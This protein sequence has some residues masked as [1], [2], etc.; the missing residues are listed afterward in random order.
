MSIKLDLSQK[1]SQSLRLSPQ[2][3]HAIKLLQLGRLDYIKEIEQQLLENPLL[4]DSADSDFSESNNE[5]QV[6]SK[7]PR[8]CLLYTSPSPRD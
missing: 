3:K 8:D 6:E 4:E 7:E 5:K 2:L 1:L